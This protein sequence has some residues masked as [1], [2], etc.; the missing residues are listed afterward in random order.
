MKKDISIGVVLPT[1]NCVSLLPEHL[2]SMQQWLDLVSEVVVV[3]SYSNDGTIEMIRERLLHP[4]LRI[5]S[6]PRGLYQS[7]NFGLC[8][9]H[10]KYAY[11]STVGDT[12]TRLGL[13]HLYTVAEQF[14]CDVVASEPH[15]IANDGSAIPKAKWPIDNVLSTLRINEPT[16]IE[17]V[18]LFLFVRLHA[19]DG[20]AILGSSASNLYRTELLQNRPFPTDFGTV[21]DGAWGIVNVFDYRLGVTPEKFSTFRQHPKAY[22]REQYAVKNICQR[23]LLLAEETLQERL[24]QD[25]ALRRDCECIGCDDFSS[26]VNELCEWNYRLERL[27]KGKRFWLFNPYAWH[28]RAKRNQFRQ[29][30]NERKDIIFR[31][32]RSRVDG[33]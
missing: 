24:A 7:W 33:V 18:I 26:L 31:N 32:F 12:I 25:V 1:L 13:E 6:H 17:G 15:F 21:G 3:D 9:L 30:L 22:N 16:Y 29:L 10:T 4:R 27:R 8:Q 28:V 11:I 5:L 23:L 14:K 19:G 20:A 2:E